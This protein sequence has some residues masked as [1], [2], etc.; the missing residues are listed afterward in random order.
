VPSRL[1]R[2]WRTRY[3]NS[4][5][6]RVRSWVRL[7]DLTHEDLDWFGTRE[8]L[9]LTPEKHAAHAVRRFVDVS[10]ELMFLL[11]F[12]LAEGS[13]S[14]RGGIR[15]SIG[16]S[17]ERFSDEVENAI[18]AVFGQPATKYRS[19]SRVDEVRIVNRVLAIAWQ[20]LFGFRGAD[21]ITKRIPGSC[22][23][24]GPRAP[25]ILLEGVSARRRDCRQRPDW[26]RDFL[27]RSRE[28]A[29]LPPFEP[30]RDR[31]H[32]DA[33]TRPNGSRDPWSAV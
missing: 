1:E 18:G 11:G 10:P 23:P 2:L 5:R 25:T 21:S 27:S 30:R 15:F 31:I 6:N 7:S 24:G 14:D 29:S 22:L 33:R 8:D 19:P 3:R 12:Y 4:G 16:R 20:D 13:S 17:N 9:E 32:V 28:R 26:L